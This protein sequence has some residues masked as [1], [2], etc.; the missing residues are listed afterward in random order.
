[1]SLKEMFQATR[2]A[3]QP[4]LYLTSQHT[5]LTKLNNDVILDSLYMFPFSFSFVTLKFPSSS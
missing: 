4:R 2:L 5:H 3:N 1:M